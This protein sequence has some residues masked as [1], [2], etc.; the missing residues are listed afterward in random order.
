MNAKLNR[1]DEQDK[2]NKI[3]GSNLQYIRKLK[4]LL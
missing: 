1:P 4:G 2:L 3:I